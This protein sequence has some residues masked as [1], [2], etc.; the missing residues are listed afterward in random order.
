MIT[1]T[2]QLEDFPALLHQF[3]YSRLVVLADE[4]TYR[5]CYPLLLPYL[6]EQHDLI[7]VLAG[8]AHKSIS[9]CEKVWLR[10]SELR[11]DRKALM[12][13]LGGGVVTDMGGFIAGTYKRGIRFL[14]LPTTLLGMV[15][16]AIGGKVGIDLGSLKNQLGLFKLPEAIF[17][18]PAFL[19]TLPRRIWLSGFAEVIK[20]Y[21]VADK[22][23]WQNLQ[24]QAFDAL[25][26]FS[27]IQ[28]AVQIKS[29][30][31]EQDME[32]QHLRKILNFGHTVG[33]AVESYFLDFDRPYLLHGEAVALGM[34]A[35]AQLSYQKGYLSEGELTEISTYL[36]RHFSLPQI[37]PF[38]YPA[39]FEFMQQDK[40]NKHGQIQ[41]VLLN[42]IGEAVWDETL[43]FEEF[44][45]AVDFTNLKTSRQ[46]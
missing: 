28:K 31:V 32:E 46:L 25:D 22:E 26:T 33:H 8:E 36:S 16:A 19:D 14:H 4:N 27:L 6:P 45:R 7:V 39:I 40:K 17:I 34:I 9:T 20:H 21:L 37:P 1:I 15:D 11:L 29:E 35:E 12:L 38:A 5:H 2:P 3:D 44:A 18:C 10:M 23:A 41:A 42:K 24:N 30:V 13:N 43:N